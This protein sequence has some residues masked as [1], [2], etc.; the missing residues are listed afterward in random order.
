MF[1]NSLAHVISQYLIYCFDFNLKCFFPDLPKYDTLWIMT[2]LFFFYCL[3]L[4]FCLAGTSLN[5]VSCFICQVKFVKVRKSDPKTNMVLLFHL[6]CTGYASDSVCFGL[7]ALC[8]GGAQWCFCK[9]CRHLGYKW[10]T[11][12]IFIIFW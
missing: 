5:Q 4:L 8:I 12:F 1:L 6:F 3:R 10:K 2:I 7:S 9:S 11:V